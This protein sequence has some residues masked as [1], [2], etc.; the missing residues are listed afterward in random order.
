MQSQTNS[1][2]TLWLNKKHAKYMAPE[3]QNEILRLMAHSILRTITYC[4]HENV[5][6]T[7]MADEVTDASNCE[8][9][10]LCLRWVD[11]SFDVSEDL[12]G[13]YR[14]DNICSS[15]LTSAIKDVLLCLNLRISNCRG[16]CYDGASNMVG[17]R[18]G[19]ATVLQ[20]EEPRAILT[21]CYGHSLQLAVCD[22]VKQVKVM[23]DALD[24]T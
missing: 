13:L 23:Q 21:H 7:I 9:F 15:T 3:C 10:V 1:D 2:I 8:Q 12:I 14:V 16:Q 24:T 19:V 20:R 6:Y 11:K 17:I 4:I 18:S 5:Y 22:T